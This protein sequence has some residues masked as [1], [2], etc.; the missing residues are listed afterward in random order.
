MS[1]FE[2]IKEFFISHA[3]NFVC[4]KIISKEEKIKE[5]HLTDY[6]CQEIVQNEKVQD[7]FVMKFPS[8]DENKKL[9][10]IDS[11][12]SFVFDIYFVDYSDKIVLTDAGRTFDCCV[13]A[14]EGNEVFASQKDLMTKYLSKYEITNNLYT[15]EK[16][17]TL[18]TFIS[19]TIN[20]VTALQT[21]N[22][23]QPYPPYVLE[24]DNAKQT[25]DVLSRTWIKG[26]KITDGSTGR[27][28]ALFDNHKNLYE[29]Q[30]CPENAY[31][32]YDNKHAFVGIFFN[33]ENK[34]LIKR[35][36]K[37]TKPQYDFAIKDYILEN[38]SYS[39]EALQR[40]IH[41]NFGIEFWFGEVAPLITTIK[42]KVITDYYVVNNY[43]I[44][45]N[46][47]SFDDKEVAYDWVTLEELFVLIRSGDFCPYSET[48][49]NYVL[50]IKKDM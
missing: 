31:C 23:A 29:R 5:N 19:D 10:T 36:L 7:F 2:K 26:E 48:F 14:F 40:A 16:Q 35:N 42:D 11:C 8:N 20:F 44:S 15:V 30:T 39:L 4:Y 46:D 25:R 45:I 28:L 37:G 9:I 33:E 41:D 49:I 27:L 17:T 38:E 34:V 3:N 24:L 50:E 43:N 6:V 21:I 18:A 22:N 13:E 32:E 12:D 47:L 1:S